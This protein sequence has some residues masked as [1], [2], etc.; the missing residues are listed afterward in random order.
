MKTILNYIL[1]IVLAI[2]LI[3]IFFVNIVYNT[4]LNENYI[5]AKLEKENYYTKIHKQI[6]ENFE[7]Y[8]YQSGLE[9]TVLNNIVTIDKVKDD[10]KIIIGNIY[11]GTKQEINV[12]KIREKLNTNI[13]NS[14]STTHMT[15]NQ[16]KSIDTYIDQICNE[17]KVT[18]SYYSFT[19]KIGDNF[20]NILKIIN[21]VKNVLLIIIGI[22]FLLLFV[23]N[24]KGFYKFI[25]FSGISFAV[26][27][28]ILVCFNVLVNI[29]IKVNAITILN[30]VVS[31]IL[32]NVLN[33]ELKLI[34]NY[35]IIGI[36]IGVFLI[37]ISNL[38]HNLKENKLNK[39]EKN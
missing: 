2:L 22:A 8:I 23:L 25:S 15:E 33:E 3:A 18:I 36:L 9:E 24:L 19:T 12:E 34:I 38:L 13:Q 10:T 5:L 31:E 28:L 26:F 6:E 20:T 30:D 39:R 29:R 37:I 11:R 7:N 14:L 32:R 4:V 1:S 27:G 35:G 21:Q 16:K 17:Y